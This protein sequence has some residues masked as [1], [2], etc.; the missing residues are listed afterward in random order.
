ME[1]SST[2]AYGVSERVR[3]V[4]HRHERIGSAILSTPNPPSVGRPNYV[5]KVKE[6]INKLLHVG[7]IRL[8]K[9]AT[10][11]IPIVVLLK[12]NGQIQVCVDYRKLN[13]TTIT[14]A[15]PLPFMDNILDAVA[16]HECYNFLDGFSG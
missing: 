8:V 14:Y 3:T 1:N 6:E 12:K 15:F 10:W 13:A 5:V 16:G 9:W 11:L 2:T 4:L 7:F